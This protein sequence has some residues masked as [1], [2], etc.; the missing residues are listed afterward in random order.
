[1]PS[2][3]R[4]P[5]AVRVAYVI[6]AAKV[7]AVGTELFTTTSG[8]VLALYSLL[9]GRLVGFVFVFTPARCFIRPRHVISPLLVF[10]H[11]IRAYRTVELPFFSVLLAPFMAVLAYFPVWVPGRTLLLAQALIF[12][13]VRSKAYPGEPYNT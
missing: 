2:T 7:A 3:R 6:M 11:C 4:S 13:A 12:L 10:C 1:M 5:K 9:S 8:P